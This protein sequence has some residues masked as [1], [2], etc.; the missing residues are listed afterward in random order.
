MALA[1]A[2][3]IV[4]SYLSGIQLAL[5]RK[6]QQSEQEYRAAETARAQAQI[7]QRDKEFAEEVKQHD[8]A[9][10]ASLAQRQ[11]E[12]ALHSKELAQNMNPDSVDA[13]GIG[14][15]SVN[16]PELGKMQF[17]A[18]TVEQQQNLALLLNQR[19]KQQEADISR[20]TEKQRISQEQAA[21]ISELGV[22]NTNALN[23][24]GARSKT[25]K[26]LAQLREAGENHRAAQAHADNLLR[27]KIENGLIDP[28]VIT[29]GNPD[30]APNQILLMRDQILDGQKSKED[31]QGL[32][33]GIRQ[34]VINAVTQAGGIIPDAKTLNHLNALKEMASIAPRMKE[35]ISGQPDTSSLIGGKIRGGLQSLTDPTENER[36]QEIHGTLP[37]IANS[38]GGDAGQRLTDFKLGVAGGAYSPDIFR[39]KT[40]NIQR[41]NNFIDRIYDSAKESLGGI[42]DAQ[43][44]RIITNR[45]LDRLA[46]FGS[47]PKAI[48][49]GGVGVGQPGVAVPPQAPKYPDPA[50]FDLRGK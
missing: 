8:L 36:F 27:I 47:D 1:D 42:P 34:A 43:R 44:A 3:G 31:L 2:N 16:D 20:E 35:A 21:R 5:Q 22:S 50:Q 30:V 10:K 12:Y 33:P 45:G 6:Q 15:Y 40:T 11:L 38:I 24:E 37:N 13:K 19:Q 29:G 26:E 39:P 25:E 17:T 9:H 46:A 14:T 28:S 41:Y 23:L 4:D 18:P 32:R 48:V 7:Q 49:G